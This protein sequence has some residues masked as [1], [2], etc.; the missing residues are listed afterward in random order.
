MTTKAKESASDRVLSC[1]EAVEY[2]DATWHKWPMPGGSPHLYSESKVRRLL[3]SGYW[4]CTRTASG[5]LGITVRDLWVIWTPK[6]LKPRPL[7]P[8]QQAR[9]D[10]EREQSRVFIAEKVAAGLV[11]DDKTW[12]WIKGEPVAWRFSIPLAQRP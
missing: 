2:M 6:K 10:R 9:L 4:P 1:R 11:W 5:H 3:N 8:R 12:Q 7:T